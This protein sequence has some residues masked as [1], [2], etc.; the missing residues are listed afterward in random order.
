MVTGYFDPVMGCGLFG[1]RIGPDT[2]SCR[3]LEISLSELIQGEDGEKYLCRRFRQRPASSDIR[4][5]VSE[6]V[7]FFGK[8]RTCLDLTLSAIRLLNLFYTD[9]PAVVKSDGFHCR[10]CL[11]SGAKSF[12]LCRGG[13]RAHSLSRC[14]W[15]IEINRISRSVHGHVSII[16]A[17]NVCEV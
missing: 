9:I 1:I 7:L 16:A 13:R 17:S 5:C 3:S 14:R 10:W 4:T 11:K 6:L 12:D 15:G 2:Y 8:S